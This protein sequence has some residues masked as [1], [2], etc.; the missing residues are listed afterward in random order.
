MQPESRSPQPEMRTNS[1]AHDFCAALT[2]F[3]ESS[4]LTTAVFF[5]QWS[6]PQATGYATCSQ[7]HLLEAG[8]KTYPCTAMRNF[9]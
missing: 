5:R 6:A 9:A 3:L 1:A 8:L 4:P 2:D 7:F